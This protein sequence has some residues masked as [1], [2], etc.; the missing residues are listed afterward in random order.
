MVF[1]SHIN[2]NQNWTQSIR[3]VVCIYFGNESQQESRFIMMNLDS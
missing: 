2:S 3:V 1:V